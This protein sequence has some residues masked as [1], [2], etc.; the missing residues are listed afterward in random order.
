VRGLPFT[1]A[2]HLQRAFSYFSLYPALFWRALRIPLSASSSQ[3]SS[4]PASSPSRPGIIITLTDPPLLLVLGPVL[5]WFKKCKL[6]H[7]AQD[8]YPEVAEELDVIR[9]GGLPARLLRRLSTWAM[10]R[11]DLIIVVGR[12]MKERL[13]QRGIDPDKIVVIPNWPQTPNPEPL[14]KTSFGAGEEFRQQHGWTDRFVVMYSGNF[15]LAHPF[16]AI[17][18]AIDCLEKRAPQ[19]L[20]AFIGS[21]PR[22]D[23][24][25]GQLKNRANVRFLPFQSKEKLRE[26]L[27]AADLHLASMSENLCGLV[28][29]S[30]VYGV[31]AAERP[32]I[33]IGP[34]ESE[35][36]RLI[37][38]FEC[39]T[40]IAC[41]DHAGL[42][43]AI[44]EYAFDA[45]LV[46][47]TRDNTKNAMKMNRF[48]NAL[49][50]FEKA[51]QLSSPL[52]Q[53]RIS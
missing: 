24:L 8:I 53:P 6:I 19:I 26:S 34:K 14:S 38:G 23:G 2:N 11:H 30:K 3:P 4:R 22:L 15:G 12:C 25:A 10:R 29:P 49:A 35:V 46:R 48:A 20:F 13:I 40:V 1:R 9:K 37:T 16:E 33:F 18:S 7:W 52:S 42:I 28:V 21:G 45:K 41:S 43:S 31:L 39:G 51:L 44:C 27:A 36:A 50:A 17:V 32:C 5:K 47:L